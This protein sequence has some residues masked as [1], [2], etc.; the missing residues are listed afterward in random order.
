MNIF[1]YENKG[2]QVPQKIITRKNFKYLEDGEVHFK[3]IFFVILVEQKSSDPQNLLYVEETFLR[4]HSHRG[5]DV[6]LPLSSQL[7]ET[8]K[9]CL[10]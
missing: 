1:F 8:K 10:E 4:R 2:K 7:G 3:K 9:H 6:Y 5:G